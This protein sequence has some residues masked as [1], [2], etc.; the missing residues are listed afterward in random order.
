[1][2]HILRMSYFNELQIFLQ[3]GVK[4]TLQS[5]ASLRADSHVMPHVVLTYDC[6]GKFSDRE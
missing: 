2:C 3:S 1:M 4:L 5:I 6:C